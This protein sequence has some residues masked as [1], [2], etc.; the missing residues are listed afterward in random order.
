MALF[1][2]QQ[3]KPKAA[4]GDA[5]GGGDILDVTDASFMADVVEE[6][7]KRPVV[8]DFWAPWCGPCRQLGPALEKAVTAAKGKVRLAKVNV[9]ENPGIAGQ[10][11]VQS[12]PAVF[13]ID[14]GKAFQG[15]TGALPESQ[16]KAFIDELAASSGVPGAGAGGPGDEPTVDEVLEIAG[17]VLAEGDAA[18][19]AEAYAHALQLEP[20][21]IKAIAGLARCYL[22]LGDADRAREIAAMAP[23]E[24]ADP[25]LSAVRAQLALQSGPAAE[26][27]P[28]RARLEADANDH[29]ARFDL[30]A[31]LSGRGDLAGA[32]DELLELMRRERG[33]NDD[34]ARKQLLTVFEAAGPASDVAKNGRR[35]LSSLLFA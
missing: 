13:V 11:R 32:A 24:A 2:L 10:F 33:W 19:A 4:E 12:I 26:D 16:V 29:Q 20:Q 22:Q 31:A 34:A 17:Q 7:Q 9:D 1:G 35:R 27:A 5:P 14:G 6:S 18:G 30:A 3:P 8:I 21:N 28:L 23:A 25:E 15:F